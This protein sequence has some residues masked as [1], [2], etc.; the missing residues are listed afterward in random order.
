METAFKRASQ[1][2]SAQEAL[3]LKQQFE[4]IQQMPGA[5]GFFRRVASATDREQLE[6]YLAEVCYALIFAGLQFEVQIEPLGR[7]GPDLKVSRDGH[8]AFIEVMHFRKISMG[9]LPLGPSDENLVLS[10]YGNSSRDIRKAFEKLLAKFRQVQD[11]QAIIAIWNDD[12]DIEEL[13][14][15]EAVLSLR[16]DASHS[17]LVLPSGILFV[18]YGSPWKRMRDHKQLYCFPLHITE[19]S[20]QFGW[21]YEL[22]TSTVN[23]LIQRALGVC[24]G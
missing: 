1:L 17:A 9:P 5:N 14:V 20:R 10:D 4:R 6:D 13:E 22:E 3:H 21:I 7:K 2:I 24:S 8:E 16:E 15:Q 11:M 18:L 19:Q 23:E 12:G